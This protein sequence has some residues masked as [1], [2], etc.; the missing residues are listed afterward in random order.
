VRS[1]VGAGVLIL[2][3]LVAVIVWIIRTPFG[4]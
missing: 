2:A 3:A 4:P 1:D